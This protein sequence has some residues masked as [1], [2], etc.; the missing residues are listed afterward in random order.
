MVYSPTTGVYY[1]LFDQLRLKK[2]DYSL[3][4][5]DVYFNVVEKVKE[6]P[7]FHKSEEKIKKMIL[8]KN[9]D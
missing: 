7:F 8:R 1:Q 4:F 2:S 9:E 6:N 5:G 3:E